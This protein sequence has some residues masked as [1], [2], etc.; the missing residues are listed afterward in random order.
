MKI[1]VMKWQL[2]MPVLMVLVLVSLNG[3]ANNYYVA[4]DGDDLNDGSLSSPFLTIA[5]ATSI[6]SAGDT[7]FIKAGIYRETVLAS[8]SGTVNNPIVY[9]NYE[10][11]SVLVSGTDL[12]SNWEIF[13]GN[14]Y[15]ATA[16]MPL[17]IA[18][19]VYCNSKT[20]DLARW[21][22][23][24]DD[25]P[26][27]VDATPVSGGTASSLIS[28]NSIPSGDW[29]G[30]YLW[31]LG[32]HSGTSWIREI[33]GQSGNTLNFI[34]VDI[35]IW[36]FSGH[37]PSKLS[38]GNRGQFYLVGVLDALDYEREWYYDAAAGKLYFQAPDNADP[39]TFTVEATKREHSI[40]VTG[41]YV[42]FDG[43]DAFGGK[44]QISGENCI[45][46]NGY[47]LNCL[48]RLDDLDGAAAVFTGA[49]H[50]GGVNAIFDHNV[51]DGSS[52]N[53]VFV[54]GWGGVQNVTVSHNYIYNSNTVG[55]H[56]S[57]IRAAGDYHKF[58]SNTI[59]GTGRDGIYVGGKFNEI[60]YNDFS[61]CM[62]INN[63]GG[64]F[65]TVG[66]ADLK[67]NEIHH[68]WFHDAIGPDYADGRAAGIYLDNDSKGW[69][70]HH[71]VV[72]NVSWTGLQ[73][74]WNN[75]D[76]DFFN[77]T[78]VDVGAATGRWAN[79]YIEENNKV[80]N[81]YSTIGDWSTVDF[82][83]DLRTNNI[84]QDALRD[85]S[86]KDFIPRDDSQ[87]VDRGFVIE[88]I[89]DNALDNMPDIGAYE[90][91][92]S[93]WIPGVE[94]EYGDEEID[95]GNDPTLPEPPLN[96]EIGN[97]SDFDL[98]PN[99]IDESGLHIKTR[100][101]SFTIQIYDLS[102]VQIYDAKILSNEKTVARSVFRNK[103]VY[104]MH[105]GIGDIK[106]VRKIAV[107]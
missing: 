46:K 96:V 5:K 41:N 13:D 97:Q 10:S 37:N 94:T 35:S 56:S 23:N 87:L 25:D 70:V 65:Y 101:D 58:I 34:G 71:N 63:D 27:T 57:P 33:T 89:T 79:G 98:Y 20:M 52:I 67:H 50:I 99:P 92:L 59:K 95:P 60:A 88:G 15:Q 84:S 66:N 83:P 54:Q 75:T 21:P 80:W 55:I 8:N 17:G 7:C 90:R 48:Q 14:I 104:L 82:I 47:F 30:G 28:T 12:I 4:K 26:Y 36:P 2:W 44:V 53:G 19:A 91:G 49:I 43:I 32:G 72:W 103:G 31:Y 61:Q 62:L 42:V 105:I 93:A 74:N 22:N 73:V 1:R 76:I 102:G 45:I 11:D 68:N 9:T 24:V 81:N 16:D 40:H 86:M 69:S 51:V 78:F 29:I 39:S 6:L 64:L 107:K 106:H 85:P 38:N 18:N 3:A 100:K 77:N